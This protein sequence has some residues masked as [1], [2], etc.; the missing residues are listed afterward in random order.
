MSAVDLLE[1]LLHGARLV[2]RSSDFQSQI[3]LTSTSWERHLHVNLGVQ[4]ICQIPARQG[5]RYLGVDCF[6]SWSAARFRRRSTPGGPEVPTKMLRTASAS[7]EW[8]DPAGSDAT[9]AERRYMR[10][11][12][13]IR[14]LTVAGADPENRQRNGDAPLLLAAAR[15][16]VTYGLTAHSARLL[17]RLTTSARRAS[18]GVRVSDQLQ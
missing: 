6:R 17:S 15:G 1:Y 5:S 3:N 9:A 11:R 2:H 16:H 13:A 10:Y 8:P 18:G 14:A 12:R 4:Y 7:L